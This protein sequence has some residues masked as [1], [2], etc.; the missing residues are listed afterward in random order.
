MGTATSS[1]SHTIQLVFTELKS[2]VNLEGF[3]CCSQSQDESSEQGHEGG[4][5][6]AEWCRSFRNPNHHTAWEAMGW[7]LFLL[8]LLLLLLRYYVL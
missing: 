6:W 5:E 3:L 2:D 7:V 8:L 4:C 1:V